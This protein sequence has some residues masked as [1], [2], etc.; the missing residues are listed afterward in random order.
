MPIKILENSGSGFSL[1]SSEDLDKNVGWWYSLAQADFDNDGDMDFIAGNLGLNYKYKATYDEPF[2]VYASDFDENGSLDIVLG[3]FNNG[4]LYPLRGRQCSSEQMPF[5]KKKF[6]SYH[7]FGLATLDQ[8]YGKEELEN[9]TNF[10]ATNFASSY[11]ENLGNGKFKFSNLPALSQISSINGIVIDDYDGDGQ[12]DLLTAGNLY[13][14]EVETIRNDASYALMLKGMGS[15]QFQAVEL[16]KSGFKIKG[17]V[18]SLKTLKV[19][20]DKVIV[21]AL[22]DD[23]PVFLKAN[24][25]KEVLQ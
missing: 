12:L 2:K 17:D 25:D 8:V 19:G 13:P 9:S 18:K 21:A 15:G 3:Y 20:S 7:D 4:E 24:G 23:R 22:N 5:I 1:V 11:I 10:E 14:V 16:T 6:E